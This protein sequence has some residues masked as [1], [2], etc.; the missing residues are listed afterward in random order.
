MKLRLAVLPLFV[1]A[2]FLYT[3]SVADRTTEHG[4]KKVTLSDLKATAKNDLS[5][6]KPSNVLVINQ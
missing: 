4:T 6:F 2:A 1:L 3:A 5:K